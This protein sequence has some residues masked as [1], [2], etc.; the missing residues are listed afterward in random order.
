VSITFPTGQSYDFIVSRDNSE[1]WRWSTDRFF[2]QAIREATIAAGNSL[3]FTET[4][5]QT[6]N[7]VERVPA[8]TYSVTG[9]LTIMD[10]VTTPPA[11]FRITE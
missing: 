1:V 11:E 6:N 7:D 3:T 4:W 2:T 10:S 5:D 8:G 9:I